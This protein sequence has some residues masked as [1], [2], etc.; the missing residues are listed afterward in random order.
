VESKTVTLFG[1]LRRH[2]PHTVMY[3]V[4]SMLVFGLLTSYGIVEKASDHLKYLHPN[5]NHGHD[6]EHDHGSSAFADMQFVFHILHLVLS[7]IATTALF[8]K[9]DSSII[10]SVLVG[11]S[12]AVVWCTLS[13]VLMPYLASSWVGMQ[14]DMHICLLEHPSVVIPF[15]VAGVFIGLLFHKGKTH[16]VHGGHVMISCLA[17]VLY[18]YGYASP[19]EPWMYPILFMSMIVAV[20][21]PCCMSD[22]V[23]PLLLSKGNRDKSFSCSH[24]D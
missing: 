13:D 22:I 8:Y 17:S 3:V 18:L 4:V 12:G 5:H 1:E 14:V 7:S 9:Y 6:C 23:Y 24:C 10:K 15:V 11:F 16:Y 19:I 21:I 2:L 20:V